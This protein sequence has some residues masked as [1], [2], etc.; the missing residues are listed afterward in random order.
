[1]FNRLGSVPN[2]LHPDEK[3]SWLELPDLAKPF[4]FTK[5]WV[6][7]G[8]PYDAVKRA[9]ARHGSLHLGSEGCGMHWLLIVSGAERGNVWMY[10]SVGVVPLEPKRSFLDWVE[11]WLDGVTEWWQ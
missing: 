8:E 2:D 10:T 3:R 5:P 4:P 1:M 9:T 6:W 7:E 11:A